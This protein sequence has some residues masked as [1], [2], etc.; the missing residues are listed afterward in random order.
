MKDRALISLRPLAADDRSRLLN[1]RNSSD[2]AANMFGDHIVEPHEH[3][4]WFEVAR[5]DGAH[6]YRV[7]EAGDGVPV[8]LIYLTDLANPSGSCAWG[9]YLAEAKTRGRG[10]GRLMLWRSLEL[11]FTK[12]ARD[13][14]CV[15]AFADNVIAIGVYESLGFRRE[16][17]LRQHVWKNGHRRDV[18]GLGL[19]NTE[20]KLLERGIRRELKA[21]GLLL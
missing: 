1:W 8:G 21:K 9:G 17:Y 15:E 3:A 19:L 11:A 10:L 14:V 7:V 5:V 18:V 16:A 13:K 20:W 2:V 6:L 4:E 12:L